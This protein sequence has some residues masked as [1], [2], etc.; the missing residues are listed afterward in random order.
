MGDGDVRI[1]KE[2]SFNS[3]YVN[4]INELHNYPRILQLIEK[5]ISCMN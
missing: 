5:E 2:S 3:I 4:I 1:F